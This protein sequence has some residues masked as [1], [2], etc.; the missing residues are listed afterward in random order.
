MTFNRADARRKHEWK[1]HR[2]PEAK[3]EK[4]KER[5]GD[6]EAPQGEYFVGCA[7]LS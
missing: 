6:F 3:P 2:L 7:E 1:Q 4:R 5:R